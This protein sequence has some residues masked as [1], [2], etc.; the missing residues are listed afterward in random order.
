MLEPGNGGVESSKGHVAAIPDIETKTSHLQT[1]PSLSPTFLT[2]FFY[3]MVFMSSLVL[4][5]IIEVG[6]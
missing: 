6:S 2:L 3:N 4:L 5:S 1:L